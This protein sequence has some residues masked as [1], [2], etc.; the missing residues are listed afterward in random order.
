MTKESLLEFIRNCHFSRIDSW[1]TYHCEHPDAER[2]KQVA[3]YDR[4]ACIGA[5]ATGQRCTLHRP[6]PEAQNT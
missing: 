4:M 1:G 5:T 3:G 6:V 2:L